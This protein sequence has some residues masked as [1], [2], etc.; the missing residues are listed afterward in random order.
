MLMVKRSYREHGNAAWRVA[1]T[2]LL[3]SLIQ[4]ESG[5][6]RLAEYTK[7]QNLPED[8]MLINVQ[9]DEPLIDI[10][11]VN[12]LADFVHSNGSNYATIC[13][14]FESSENEADV[15]K[16]KVR[17]DSENIAVSD[18]VHDSIYFA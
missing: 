16:V 6:D 10:N 17:I 13:K 8:L 18:V 12:K 2:L 7:Y 14:P 4:H 15:N 11:S 1:L 3:L 9:G 5:T